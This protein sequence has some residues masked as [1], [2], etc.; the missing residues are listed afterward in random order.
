MNDYIYPDGVVTVRIETWEFE[1][2]APLPV[3]GEESSWALHPMRD[4]LWF[5][6]AVPGS[7]DHVRVEKAPSHFR[8]APSLVAGSRGWMETAVV[9]ELAVPARA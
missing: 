4:A 7:I 3:V 2:C 9:V 6:G 5:A 1:C 8:G